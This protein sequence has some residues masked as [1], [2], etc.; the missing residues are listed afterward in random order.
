MKV[1]HNLA[2]LP[3]FKNTIITIGS[4]DGVHCGHQ[5][6]IREVTAL[7]K[8][9]G[10]PSIVIT[11]HPHPRLVLQPDNPSISLL[12][13]TE[14]KIK[15]LEQQGIDIVVVVPFTLEFAN[16]TPDNYIE[17]FLIKY[18]HPAYIVIG[19]DHH[20]G[21]NRSGNIHFLQNKAAQFGYQIVEIEKK[22]IEDI[23]V[24]STK[25]RNALADKNIKAANLLLG[26]PYIFTGKIVKGQQIGRE[27]GFPTA[28]IAIEDSH[29]LLPPFGIYAVFIKWENR[30]C[31]GMM[32]RGD[33]PVLKDFRNVT[34]EVNI[35]DFKEDIYDKNVTVEVI[36]FIRDDISFDSLESLIVQLA[37]D[38]RAS[39]RILKDYES[40]L[41]PKVAIVI[42]NW[43][44]PQ[45]LTQFLPSVCGSRYG[46]LD[47]YVADNASTD[48]SIEAV[49]TLNLE[50]IPAS[51]GID[52]VK[53]I[54]L[55]ENYGFAKGYNIALNHDKLK[56]RSFENPNGYDYYVLLNSDC[57][58]SQG[59]LTPIIDLMQNDP[60]IAVAQPK[61]LH[62][63]KKKRFEYAGAAGGWIDTLGY[64]FARGRL[65]D[66]LEKDKKQYDDIAEIFWAS[67]AAMV[68]KTDIWH[69]FGGFD[70]DL[71]AHM[72]EIDFCWRV[73]R[74]GYKVMV[75]PQ[76]SVRHVGG[77]TMDYL[78]PRKA[79]LN[80]RNNL[81]ILI[82]NE[83]FLKLLWLIPLRLIL[84]G[85]AGVK[86]LKEK[87]F[88][89]IWAIIRA[90]FYVYFHI[91]HIIDK[92]HKTT[93]LIENQRIAPPN[94]VGI[95]RG[96]I[97]WKYF[98]EGK[99][100]FSQLMIKG[101]N[102]AISTEPD[103]DEDED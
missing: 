34:I 9:T 64:P 92:R 16:Q 53:V 20:F 63:A 65:F 68:V 30:I 24:S 36:D 48:N 7:A 43:N 39:R 11:F 21:A 58:T 87:Q 3:E 72:E 86:F 33:R 83:P 51:M 47:I 81:I 25:I 69:R 4:F 62:Y 17:N 77:G 100:T 85:L 37:E 13:T 56:T 23:A 60:L 89:H 71:W 101:K 5:H 70:V 93:Q 61:I 102:N 74:A 103:I 41:M 59:W 88:K 90:H 22:I 26:N 6:I 80:F 94:M 45:Y 78:S 76:V 57:R 49:R 99:K 55:K 8:K 27:I 66:T 84:D 98:V 52:R 2:E 10:F 82:K 44:T 14:E 1:Y 73:K 67:G 19:Y 31:K 28:N 38:E 75:Q 12:T 18:F 50:G 79:Y 54:E 42:L 91:F 40:Q 96:S 95:L 32:Y 97:V 29:K 35:F 15:L 46:N